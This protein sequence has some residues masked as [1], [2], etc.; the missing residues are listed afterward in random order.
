MNKAE[1]RK[2]MIYFRDS[3]SMEERNTKSHAIKTQL[4]KLK[5]Y[6]DAEVIFVYVSFRSEVDTR[7]FIKRAK[8]DGK[9]IAVPVSIPKG[10]VLQPCE[11]S[12]L[13][14]LVPGTWGI[15]EPIKGNCRPVDSKEIDLAVVPGLAFDY[16]FH[17]LGYGAGYYDRFL[18]SLRKETTKVG[19]GYDFQLLDRIPVEEFDVPLSGI[20]TEVRLL[21]ENEID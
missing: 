19:I 5:A 18:P 6:Q 20:I 16:C 17:R 12:S 8:K 11:I 14:D 10:K 3:L 4:T 1:L 2:K 13:D 9:R 15:L 7:C 21:L